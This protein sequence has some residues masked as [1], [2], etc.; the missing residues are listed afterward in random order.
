MRQRSPKPIE[1]P[2][3]QRITRA[4]IIETG[5]QAWSIV[6][7]SRCLIGMQ[8]P[9]IDARRDQSVAL[10]IDGLAIIGR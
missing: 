3:D 7:C 4:Q 6:A 8:I 10:K 2:Y 1:F 5:F 9:R